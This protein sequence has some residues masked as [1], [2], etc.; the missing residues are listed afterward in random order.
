[1]AARARKRLG[2]L[3]VEA[4]L[5]SRDQVEEALRLQKSRNERI[6]EILVDLGYVTEDEVAAALAEETGLPRLRLE[7]V[8]HSGQ[9]LSLVPPEVIRRHFVFP[10]KLADGAL[11]LAM[12]DPYNIHALD[13][14]RALTGLEIRPLVA[15]PGEIRR[16]YQRLM[17]VP[18]RARDI[19]EQ[20]GEDEERQE[21]Q[22]PEDEIG[23]APSVRMVNLILEQA[24]EARASD[25]HI[26]PRQDETIVR[27]RVDGA[28]Q[29]AMEL[30]KRL[31]G[32][33]VSRI[34]VMANLDITNRRTPQDGRTRVAFGDTPV[35]VRVSTLPTIYG[36]KVVLRLLPLQ[37]EV[38]DIEALGFQPESASAI[39]AMLARRQ[40]MILVTGPTGSGKTTTLYAFLRALN[41]PDVNIITI[42]DPVEVRMEGI[43]QVEVSPRGT[44]VTFASALRSV[45]RQDPDI[46]MVGEM[47]DE[48]TAEIAVRAAL[49]G[50]LV[51]STLHTNSAV[52]TLGRLT[53]MGVERYLVAGTVIGII[54]QRLVRKLCVRCRRPVAE[55]DPLER[56]FLGPAAE[57]AVLYEPVGC[58]ACRNTGY[59]GRLA[60]EEVLVVDKTIRG[61]IQCGAPED[62]IA[63]AAAA[64]GMVSLRQS[65]I[66]RVL[67]GETSVREVMRTVYGTVD[68]N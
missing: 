2:D 46:I 68:E 32:G 52:A 48:E 21:V 37:S 43:N 5:V 60:I 23:D 34:K 9:L 49:T 15:T 59:H 16:A 53:D 35:D 27:F 54:A 6:G 33:V 19:I 8:D 65:G 24:V 42:E 66:R 41:T 64:N 26:E 30:P 22:A 20:Y 13:D 28:L 31:A 38:M 12:A 11:Y 61:L 10:V 36:E 1:M 3:L 63:A 7:E 17:G 25:V 18:G 67:A 29:Q 14:V 57:D 45:L 44:G 58:P 62:E 39:R 4:G 55:L 47:R 56:R 40:G 51:L 50:H